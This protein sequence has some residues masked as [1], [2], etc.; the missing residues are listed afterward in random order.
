MKKKTLK[1]VFVSKCTR[2]IANHHELNF[3]IKP[4]NDEQE[5][6]INF[7]LT[8]TISFL[9]LVMQPEKNYTKIPLPPVSVFKLRTRISA[10]RRFVREI[11]LTP[12]ASLNGGGTLAKSEEA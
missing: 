9:F 6:S 11:T 4:Y 12:K 7:S 5:E 8:F 10:R 3:K 2:E 1:L